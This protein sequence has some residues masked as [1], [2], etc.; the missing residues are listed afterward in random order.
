M[1]DVKA[2]SA[3]IVEVEPLG[4]RSSPELM[5]TLIQTRKL[6]VI[7]LEVSQGMT[8]PQHEFP[9]EMIIHCLEGRV[10]LTSSRGAYALCGGQLLGYV[11]D[12]P[13]SIQGVEDAALLIFIALSSD[14]SS[15]ELIG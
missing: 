3:R 6:K 5:A 15:T 11:S 2:V 13:F 8:V 7:H 4:F 10:S 9:G 14:G 1:P 12:E